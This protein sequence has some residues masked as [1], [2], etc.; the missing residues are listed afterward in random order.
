M[1][2]ESAA[3]PSQSAPDGHLW[4]VQEII[5]ERTTGSGENEFL[6]VWKTSWIPKRDMMPYGHLSHVM[7]RWNKTTKWSSCDR[8]WNADMQVILPV[9]SGA[10]MA[11]DI[12]RS[13]AR[14]DRYNQAVKEAAARTASSDG[15]PLAPSRGLTRQ[16]L[17]NV[18]SRCARQ[19]NTCIRK[20]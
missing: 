4:E 16:P 18:R 2:F 20:R 3:N 7:R 8:C 1:A 9:E 5:A 12:A 11:A 19:I 10:A 14:R 17:V 6:V 15:S 13:T